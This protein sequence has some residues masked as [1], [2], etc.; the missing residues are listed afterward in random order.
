MQIMLKHKK[1]E[2]MGE[3]KTLATQAHT[4]HRENEKLLEF[5]ASWPHREKLALL[6]AKR[7]LSRRQSTWWKCFRK[8]KPWWKCF[9]R[10]VRATCSLASEIF[11]TG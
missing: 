4:Q 7:K 9:H 10:V 1:K 2:K 5:C 6:A 8:P 3:R 11:I